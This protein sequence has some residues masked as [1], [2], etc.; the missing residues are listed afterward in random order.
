MLI[1]HIGIAVKDIDA[2]IKLYTEICQ[3]KPAHDEVIPAAHLRLVF[4]DLGPSS[5]ELLAATSEQANLNKFLEKRGTA[6]HHIAYRVDDIA[7]ELSRLAGLGYQL[8]DQVARPSAR[9]TLIAFVDPKST[10]GVLMELVQ[11]LD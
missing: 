7:G 8:L 5:I 11:K 6:I 10:D 2:S 3:S 9:N 4:F 1:D